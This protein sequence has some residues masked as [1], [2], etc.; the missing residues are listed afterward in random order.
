MPRRERQ[1]RGKKEKETDRRGRKGRRSSGHAGCRR[2]GIVQAGRAR[3]G[4]RIFLSSRRARTS[5][6]SSLLASP[7]LA[8]SR[9]YPT[10]PTVLSSTRRLCRPVC[11][12]RTVVARFHRSP[13]SIRLLFPR[14]FRSKPT[15]GTGHRIGKPHVAVFPRR[16]RSPSHNARDISDVCPPRVRPNGIFYFP[17]LRVGRV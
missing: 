7:S 6:A 10:V 16:A 1:K 8:A 5:F 13:F 2:D 15:R 14:P 12:C 4:V 9:R 17:G 11:N 3:R